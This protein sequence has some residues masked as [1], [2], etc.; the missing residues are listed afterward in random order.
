MS[1]IDF[2]F[3]GTRS[4]RLSLDPAEFDGLTTP[5]I[6]DEIVRT[7]RAIAPD[8]SFFDE[9]VVLAAELLTRDGPSAR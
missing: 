7:L 1:S 8:T 3:M 9:D 2:Q 4:T 5:Q 6:T